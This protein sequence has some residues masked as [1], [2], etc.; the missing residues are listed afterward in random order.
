MSHKPTFLCL[1][2]YYK[3]Y[4]F[5]QAA[6]DQGCSVLL[7]TKDSLKHENWPHHALDDIFYMP[8][9]SKFPDITNAVSYL[10][11]DRK[12]DFIMPM[13]D[14]DVETAARLREHLRMPGM[15]DTTARHFRDKLAMRVQARDN[16]IQIPDFVH[17]LNYKKISEFTDRV[18]A[19]WVL[20]PRSEAGSVGIKK[21]YDKEELWKTIHNLGDIQSHYLLEQFVEGD[22][23]HVDGIVFNG[24]ILFAQA[25]Q[26][27]MPPF[28][29]WNYG[30][31]FSTASVNPDDPCLK[32]LLS[33][34]DNVV[35]AMGLQR[36]VTHAEYIRCKQTG[37]FHFLEL[38]ARVGGASIDVL[39]NKTTGINLWA[40]WVKLEL[41]YLNK[42]NYAPP[43]RRFDHG[44]LMVCLAKDERPDLSYYAAPEVVWQLNKHQ[45]AG[46]V[47]VSDSY[48]RTQEL[49]HHYTHKMAEDFLAIAPPTETA[50]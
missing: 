41:A 37:K 38:A 13:D 8:S 32:G 5:M 50:A 36:G 42:E 28:S 47:V 26:Y 16:K 17:V 44:A 4:D 18:P 29:L 6:K 48:D 14:Y 46:M 12:I 31:V 33:I 7:L 20:K 27:G 21:F 30:G 9:L 15:G 49:V 39:V 2:S 11:R 25:H 34:N 10:A 22:I 24:K 40:E 43:K 23:F 19:P 45:H 35:K 3:G 1:A